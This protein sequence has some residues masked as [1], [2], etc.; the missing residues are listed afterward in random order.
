MQRDK[1]AT[2]R[3]KISLFSHTNFVQHYNLK[4]GNLSILATSQPRE[5]K[6]RE[7]SRKSEWKRRYVL[8]LRKFINRSKNWPDKCEIVDVSTEFTVYSCAT[9]ARPN[10]L[11]C[12]APGLFCFVFS[13]LNWVAHTYIRLYFLYLRPTFCSSSLAISTGYFLISV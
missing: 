9:F 1:I 5:P 13:P 11:F 12:I 6:A 7:R 8:K 10:I 4:Y 3:K 2:E